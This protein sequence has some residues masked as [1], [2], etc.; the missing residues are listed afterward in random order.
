MGHT[1]SNLLAHTIFGTK[2]RQPL[3]DQELKSELFPYMAGI[4]KRLGVQPVII[5]GPRDH[6]HGLF[7]MPASLAVSDLM[8]KLKANS[9]RWVHQRWPQRRLFGWQEGYAAFSVSYANLGRARKYI[10][11][12]ETH[13][14]RRTFREELVAFLNQNQ[15]AYHHRWVGI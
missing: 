13:H 8:E 6:V 4:V 11:N 2:D 12:Q 7:L 1:Y 15:I 5:N 14:L 10:E 3:L 9:S